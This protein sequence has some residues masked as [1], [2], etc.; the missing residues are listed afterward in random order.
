MRRKLGKSPAKDCVLAWEVEGG[1]LLIGKKEK[2]VCATLSRE[3]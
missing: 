2:R 1:V 3:V